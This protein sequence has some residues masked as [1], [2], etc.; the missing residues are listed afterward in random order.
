ML[1]NMMVKNH[2]VISIPLIVGDTDEVRVQSEE[3]ELEKPAQGNLSGLFAFMLQVGESLTGSDVNH[4]I[5]MCF[6]CYSGSL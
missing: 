2:P 4:Q 5:T 3:P 1:V 6:G